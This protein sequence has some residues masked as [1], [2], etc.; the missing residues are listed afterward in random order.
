MINFIK[1]RTQ[2]LLSY[3]PMPRIKEVTENTDLELI[4]GAKT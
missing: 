3:E 2:K 4:S 1:F